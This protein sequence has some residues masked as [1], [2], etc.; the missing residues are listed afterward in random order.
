MSAQFFCGL[1]TWRGKI[2]GKCC[3]W[4]MLLERSVMEGDCIVI[5]RRIWYNKV[6]SLCV[7]D[8]RI[9]DD[10]EELQGEK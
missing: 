10:S 2:N 4:Y 9:N 3:L 6:E 5:Q 8:I 7:R 1:I